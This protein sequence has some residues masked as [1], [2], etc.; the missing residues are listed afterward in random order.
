MRRNFLYL[1]MLTLLS[2]LTVFNNGCGRNRLIENKAGVVEIATF[3]INDLPQATEEGVYTIG[4][5]DVLDVLF[6]YNRSYS[7]D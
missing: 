6:L 5:G 1:G 7:R 2:V 3:D 4:Y